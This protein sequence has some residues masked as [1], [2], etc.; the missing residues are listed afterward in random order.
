PTLVQWSLMLRWPNFDSAI[1]KFRFTRG[2][3]AFTIPLEFSVP[4]D[5][6]GVAIAT[7]VFLAAPLAVKVVRETVRRLKRD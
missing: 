4:G 7:S 1:L 6:T 3:A 5:N 2:G